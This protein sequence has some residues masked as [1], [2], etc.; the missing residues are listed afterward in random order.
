MASL[1]SVFISHGAPTIML[2]DCPARVFWRE[3]IENIG[4]PTSVLCVSAHWE[5]TVPTLSTA[6]EPETIHD[7]YGFPDELY[8]MSYPAPGA[9][10][11]AERAQ[12]LLNSAGMDCHLDV[13]RG[14]DHGAWIPLKEM[15]PKADVPVTQLSV[16]AGLGM[17]YHMALGRA[18]AP[19]RHEGVL[20][21]AS[22]GA[23]HNF[24]AFR[25]GGDKVPDWAL[26][27]DDWL[28]EILIAGDGA[29]LANYRNEDGALA[30]PRDEHFLPLGVA[31]GA[32]G[33]NA[34]GR[35]LHR[36]FMDGGVG[37]SAYAFE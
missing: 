26:R 18:L 11:L 27:F 35:A 21:L 24:S 28:T 29:A 36:G 4:K 32:G 8:Q 25:P 10:Q 5:T 14:L 12:A 6:Q 19:L 31:F 16:Q 17:A 7:F 23:V 2:Q 37:M 13:S 22:G 1:P 20:V 34:R 3:L 9:P 30:H 33:A 15:L